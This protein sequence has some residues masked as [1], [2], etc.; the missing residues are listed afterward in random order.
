MKI[1]VELDDDEKLELSLPPK[2]CLY[3]DLN[4]DEFDLEVE[5]MSAKLR[6]AR[7]YKRKEYIDEETKAYNR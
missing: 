5:K 6:Y 2:F 3:D 7:K 1:D 4:E